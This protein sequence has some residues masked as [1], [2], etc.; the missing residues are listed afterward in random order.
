VTSRVLL[1]FAVTVPVL[2][3]RAAPVPAGPSPFGDPALE[4][5]WKETEA[6]GGKGAGKCEEALKELGE[7]RSKK[8]R[9]RAWE[10]MTR[11]Y[12]VLVCAVRLADGFVVKNQSGLPVTAIASCGRRIAEWSAVLFRVRKSLPLEYLEKVEKAPERDLADPRNRIR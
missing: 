3:C 5:E 1:A 7:A 11:G 4:K 6:L 9:A 2:G 12:D 8:S 10:G